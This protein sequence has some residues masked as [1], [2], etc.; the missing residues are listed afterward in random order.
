MITT[1]GVQC[2]TSS[3][4][5]NPAQPVC[6]DE[7]FTCVECTAD[8]D[9]TGNLNPWCDTETYTCAPLCDTDADCPETLPSCQPTGQCV[10]PTPPPAP[11]PP[12][13]CT[14]PGAPTN[15][16]VEA[17]TETGVEICWDAPQS[18]TQCDVDSYNLD[19]TA[20]GTSIPGSSTSLCYSVLLPCDQDYTIT[21]QSVSNEAGAGGTSSPLSFSSASCPTCV[22]AP[23]PPT[24]L[25]A[26]AGPTTATSVTMDV[27]WSAVGDANAY[28]Y[29]CVVQG[30]SCQDTPE[31]SGLGETV[32]GTTGSVESLDPYTSY[33]CWVKASNDCGTTCS[34]SGVDGTTACFENPTA[35]SNLEASSVAVGSTSSI[36]IS[37]DAV[38]DA[39]EYVYFCV[40]EG[41]ACD[42]NNAQGS[43][44][45]TTSQGPGSITDL[46]PSTIYS[47]WVKSVNDC[48]DTCA[49]QGV[50]QTSACA[51]AP[52]APDAPSLV[53]PAGGVTMDLSWTA[54]TDPTA[55]LLEAFCTL[56]SVLSSC[57]DPTTENAGSV[58][59]I[60][61]DISTATSYTVTGLSGNTGYKCFVR[62]T[63]ACGTTCSAAAAQTT[64]CEALPTAPSNLAAA[65]DSS[66]SGKLDLSWTGVAGET[67]V[68]KCVDDSSGVATCSD[69]A[70]GDGEIAGTCDSGS[71]PQC[72][73]SITGL[74]DETPYTCCVVATNSEG[75]SSLPGS[76]SN[77]EKP[78]TTPIAPA[79]SSVVAS[80]TDSLTIVWGDVANAVTYNYFCAADGGTCTSTPIGTGGQGI[81]S[82]PGT[83]TGLQPD[84]YSCFVESVNSCGTMC[85]AASRGVICSISAPPNLR[86]T[87][88]TDDQL[89][90]TWDAVTGASSYE[91]F[92][93]LKVGAGAGTQTYVVPE[94]RRVKR[95]DWPS[96]APHGF[97]P[98]P[99]VSPRTAS[100]SDVSALAHPES[101]SL[102]VCR[103]PAGLEHGGRL[104]PH[105]RFRYRVGSEHS[106]CV[107]CQVGRLEQ[108]YF[109]VLTGRRVHHQ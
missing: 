2:T 39:T 66:T 88:A 68:S 104:G 40:P 62:V 29:F 57:P 101:C 65:S 55:T 75:C 43:G 26:V 12:P 80:A 4:C 20:G 25:S 70:A 21:V 48:G 100:Y 11:P 22:T 86:V 54:V 79:I 15:V 18:A 69:Q 27:S 10:D 109:D 30:G 38:S 83:V 89:D 49:S 5:A 59:T 77:P 108:L 72:T 1:T 24:G 94:S 107:L 64:P 37:W 9:C 51:A 105:H 92:C 28:Q 3:E 7:S 19:L 58:E 61:S 71:P 85:S 13:A 95:C 53:A 45:T 74:T 99:V 42:S 52:A 35:P 41:G 46:Q 78:C 82:S 60:T 36:T 106:V 56:D 91:A 47:C 34:A 32:V 50:T 103:R 93:V 44:A 73:S 98:I 63:N 17:T 6:E 14:T 102:Q 81:A 23:G 90:L 16:R 96:F 87:G 76:T 97:S 67:Y 8:A 33:T 31:G 84:P